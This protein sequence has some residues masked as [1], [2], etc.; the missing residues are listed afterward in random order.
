MPIMEVS[1]VIGVPLVIIHFRLGFSIVNHSSYG[2]PPFIETPILYHI[3]SLYPIPKWRNRSFIMASGLW[4]R[5][6][7]LENP[8]YMLSPFKTS[9]FLFGISPVG[10]LW[11]EWPRILMEVRFTIFQAI[12]IGYIPWTIALKNRPEKNRRYLQCRSLKFPLITTSVTCIKALAT[13]LADVPVDADRSSSRRKG[14]DRSCGGEDVAGRAARQHILGRIF[15]WA[16][17]PSG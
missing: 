2:V 11:W 8:P 13:R 1:W 6:M 17:I 3:D 5:N 4:Q 10:H 15:Q 12:A 16:N 14:L 7:A 9:I